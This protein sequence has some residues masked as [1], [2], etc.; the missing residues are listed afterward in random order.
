MSELVDRL[1]RYVSYQ[2][3]D[4]FPGPQLHQTLKDAADRIEYL[5]SVAGAVTASKALD[6]W[7][8]LRKKQRKE[9]I[10]DA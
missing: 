10:T 7:R 8:E 6:E 3:E 2:A 9:I 5:E 1:R 4:Y